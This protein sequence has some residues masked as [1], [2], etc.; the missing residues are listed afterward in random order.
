[1]QHS[2]GSTNM[3]TSLEIVLESNGNIKNQPHL[4]SLLHGALMQQLDPDYADILHQDSLKP[5]SQY[6]YF[7]KTDKHYIWKIN[8]INKESKLNITD[9]L[10]TG[11]NGKIHLDY[12]DIDLTIN[13]K[14]VTETTTYKDIAEDYYLKKPFNRII[15]VN[16][17]TP[18][19]FK[20]GGKFS[21][22]P[23]IHHIYNS[24]LNKWNSFAS[25]VSLKDDQILNHLVENSEMIGYNLRSTKFDLEGTRIRSFKGEICLNVSGPE[26]LVRIANLLFAFG[27]FSGVGA[28]CALGMGGIKVG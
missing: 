1:M 17:I 12:K 16:F 18:T 23:E 9:K 19:S 15:K 28:K 22:F 27:E 6:I 3:L 26:S 13:K 8:S 20:S 14:I 11:L 2:G 24:L 7:D 4:G 25:E 21:I 10:L 5:Y